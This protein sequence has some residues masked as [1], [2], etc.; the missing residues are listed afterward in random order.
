MPHSKS[1]SKGTA[2]I[3]GGAVRLG[4]VFSMTLA[5]AG[6]DLAI[7]YNSSSV[8]AAATAEE[9]IKSGVKCET[10]QF[11]FSQNG[12]V[13]ELIGNVRKQFPDLNVLKWVNAYFF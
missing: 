1:M 10:F 9:V 2:L 3:T 4:K 5:N 12:D 7:H 8:Q 6:Y 13:G 11:D